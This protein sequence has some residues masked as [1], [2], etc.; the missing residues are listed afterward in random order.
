MYIQ[1]KLKIIITMNEKDNRV[2]LNSLFDQ[3][4]YTVVYEKEILKTTSIKNLHQLRDRILD[5]IITIQKQLGL[6]Q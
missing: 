2:R 3:I 6:R 1:A 5:E 4:H